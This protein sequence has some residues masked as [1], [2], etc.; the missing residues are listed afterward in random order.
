MSENGT[1]QL[2][3]IQ[4]GDQEFGR[5]YVQ[6]HDEQ[7]NQF[8]NDVDLADFFAVRAMST[9]AD[10]VVPKSTV[11]ELSNRKPIKYELMEVLG[12]LKARV[13]MLIY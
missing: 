1:N 2:P 13:L 4:E 5:G 9:G 12:P 8:N 10:I 3:Q 7:Q 11:V 6:S